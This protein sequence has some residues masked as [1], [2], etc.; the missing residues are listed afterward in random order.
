MSTLEPQQ[1]RATLVP[2]QSFT[3][4]LNPVAQFTARFTIDPTQL[5][6]RLTQKPELLA[7]LQV[8]TFR[9]TL[10]TGLPIPG[11]EGP[12]GPPG[13]EGPEG[14]VGPAGT[15]GVQGPSGPAGP[16]G[17][18]GPAGPQ[19]IQG[20]TGSQGIQGVKGDTGIQ[21][22]A[23]PTGPTGPQGTGLQVKGTVPTA[24]NLPTSG[25]QPGDGWITADTGHLWTWSGTAWVDAG[26]LQGPPGPQGPTGATGAKGSQG[27]PGPTGAQGSTGPQGPAGATGATG[28][29]GTTGPPGVQGPAGP[30]G[31]TGTTGPQGPPGSPG[32]QGATGTTGATGAQGPQGIQGPQGLK[33][34]TGSTGPAGADSTV[35]GPQ[36]PKGD[37]GSQGDPGPT[38]SQGP[39][40]DIGPTG[41]TGAQG[42]QG[43]PGPTGTTGATGP[44][45]PPGA[46]STVPGPQGP[47]GDTGAQGPAGATGA[48]GPPGA[49]STVPGPQGPAGPKGDPGAT[50]AQGPQGDPGATGATGPAGATGPTGPPGADSTVPGPPG[51][52]GDTGATGAQGPQGDPGAQG[53]TGATGSQGPQGNTGPQGPQGPPTNIQDEGTLLTTRAAI[54][55]TGAGVTATDDAANNRYN[56]TIPGALQTPWTSDINGAGYKLNNAGAIGIG[57]TPGAT[58]FIVQKSGMTAPLIAGSDPAASGFACL[59]LS[60]DSNAVFLGTAGSGYGIA[61]Y[62]NNG[63]LRADGDLEFLTGAGAVERMRITASGNVGIGTAS[64]LNPL[65]V[66]ISATALADLLRLDNSFNGPDNGVGIAF[67][68]ADQAHLAGRIAVIRNGAGVSQDM[69]FHT[70]S[71]WST[72]DPSEK[73]RITG[74]GNVGIGTTSPVDMLSV[75]CTPQV[76]SADGAIRVETQ[77]HAWIGR[78]ALKAS[79]GGIPRLALD[80]PT[81][82]DGTFAE[83]ISIPSNGNV[84][85][86]KNNPGSKLSVVGLPTS[87]SGL[88]SGDIWIDTAAG[89]VLKIVP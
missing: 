32:P 71:S 63:F 61:A 84:G 74:A 53:P 14:P 2:K 80:G 79:S 72:T 7:T 16:D 4:T 49:D 24:A 83:R 43:V 50:G 75:A 21:G 34:D 18:T 82:T 54:N 56:V 39:K 67:A 62:R 76:P 87:S 38:G 57:T 69:V 25:N 70:S 30:Q 10:G 58:P 46:D 45:G 51:P 35:P 33:G 29:T 52:K 36:G 3:G 47:K 78:F 65:H 44:A 6:A 15:Q 42:P 12:P 5:I 86:N 27:D 59:Q 17:P 26:P 1:L 81:A 55:F 20:V 19:G 40:G 85:I 23:G 13:P 28:A 60:N 41:P 88:T 9:A 89:N 31:T 66:R 73:M 48:T 77:N 8:E 37:T 11:P 68:N 22:P 64:P